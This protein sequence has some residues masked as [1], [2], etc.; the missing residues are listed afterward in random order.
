MEKVTAPSKI[1]LVRTVRA[2]F[3][4]CGARGIAGR[5]NSWLENEKKLS[6]TTDSI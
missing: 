6:T 1:R 4:S 3:P 5:P 2:S